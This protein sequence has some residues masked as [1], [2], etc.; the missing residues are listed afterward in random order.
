MTEQKAI[1]LALE[2]AGKHIIP[3]EDWEERE[4]QIFQTIA[5]LYK[6]GYEVVP[7]FRPN[8]LPGDIERMK[9]DGINF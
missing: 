1:E 5:D 6:A 2:L 7:A 3:A 8:V 4:T 9:T